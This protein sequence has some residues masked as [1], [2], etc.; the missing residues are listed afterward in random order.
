MFIG[1]ATSDS[2]NTSKAS[3]ALPSPRKKQLKRGNVSG[4]SA[5]GPRNSPS[6]VGSDV[7]P[8]GDLSEEMRCLRAWLDVVVVQRLVHIENML[9]VIQTGSKCDQTSHTM[10]R[11]D[12][13][14]AP[15][16]FACV[17]ATCDSRALQ[18]PSGDCSFIEMDYGLCVSPQANIFDEPEQ[19][20]QSRQRLPKAG[21]P[22]TLLQDF[23]SPKDISNGTNPTSSTRATNCNSMLSTTSM[24]VSTGDDTPNDERSETGDEKPFQCK[25]STERRPSVS[26]IED[27]QKLMKKV[28]AQKGWALKAEVWHTLDNPE[29]NFIASVYQKAILG[30]TLIAVGVALCE[31]LDPPPLSEAANFIVESIFE[32]VFL[33]ELLIRLAVCPDRIN[34]AYNM[35]NIFD[36][37]AAAPLCLRIVVFLSGGYAVDGSSVSTN[38]LIGVVPILRVLKTLRGF[39]HFQLLLKALALC[40]EALPICLFAFG[41]MTLAF[42]AMIFMVEPR[43]NIT[44]FPHAMWLTIVTMT[45]LG[46]GDVTPVTTV[47]YLVIS[48]IV[49]SSVMFMAMPLGII[50]QTFTT[51]WEDRD[52]ILLVHCVREACRMWGY[53]PTDIP[54]LFE[55]YD[56]DNS[57]ELALTEFNHMME[58]MHIGLTDQRIAQLFGSI[59]I[60]GGGTIDAKEFVKV[61]FPQYFEP[62][63]GE[64]WMSDEESRTSSKERPG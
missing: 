57:G 22:A 49:V 20:W 15:A 62:I 34:F 5:R 43:D 25:R 60:D 17:A 12:S 23:C 33:L 51:V 27:A 18:M 44:S 35:H 28:E 2:R 47:G 29:H 61:L 56:D 39:K 30:I 50:G 32:C 38:V 10:S 31:S 53:K 55:W 3:C 59:D 63:F 8:A 16:T 64:S 42:A 45:T 6:K 36:A 24:E 4:Q 41:A 1:G 58:D 13:R 52:R 37:T 54:M 9:G 11:V 26:S 48:L 46:Y 40:I 19:P 21:P 14:E 7:F